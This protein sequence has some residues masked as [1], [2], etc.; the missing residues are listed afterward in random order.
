M[1]DLD[2]A[3]AETAG[4][5]FVFTWGGQEFTLPPLLSMDIQVQ[6]GL[7]AEIEKLDESNVEPAALLKIVKMVLGEDTLDRMGAVRPVGAAALMALI[8]QWMAHQGAALGK[9]SASP[10]SS[11]ST[12]QQ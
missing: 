10:D 7:V 9:S 8:Q 3:V 4:E 5:P 12:A 6:L 1:F 2:A 11:A